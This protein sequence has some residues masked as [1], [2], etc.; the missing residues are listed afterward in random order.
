M[1]VNMLIISQ[2]TPIFFLC[3]LESI[4]NMNLKNKE[5]SNKIVKIIIFSVPFVSFLFIIAVLFSI[6]TLRVYFESRKIHKDRIAKEQELIREEEKN[7]EL[8]EKIAE[9][10]SK[11]GIER[12]LREN[13][14][15][16]KPD[17]QTVILVTPKEKENEGNDNKKGNFISRFFKK[18]FKRN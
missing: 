18:I 4:L 2:I 8:K 1:T 16:K 11:D 10:E 17:E 15:I 5:K 7:K 12:H 6:S 9:L 3:F 13:F 14:D